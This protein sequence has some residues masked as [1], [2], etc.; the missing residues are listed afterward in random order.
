ME[1]KILK[2]GGPVIKKIVYGD[3]S[4][5]PLVIQTLEVDWQDI[6]T[7]KKINDLLLQAEEGNA[8][9]YYLKPLREVTYVPAWGQVKVEW[10]DLTTCVYKWDEL[11]QHKVAQQFAQTM[12]A[13]KELLK[14]LKC[15]ICN[16]NTFF[17]DVEE[18]RLHLASRPH[19]DKLADFCKGLET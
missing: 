6:P 5:H 9:S 19:R 14:K 10:P 3:A 15:K 18:F 8:E 7:E 12:T 1:K 4:V 17:D 11:S 2:W 13:R 16:P